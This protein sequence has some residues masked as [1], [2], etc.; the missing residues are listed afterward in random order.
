MKAE[1]KQRLNIT[2]SPGVYDRLREVGFSQRKA[3]SHVIED[4]LVTFLPLRV[5]GKRRAN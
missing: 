5:R 2:L 4:A 1:K 3:L